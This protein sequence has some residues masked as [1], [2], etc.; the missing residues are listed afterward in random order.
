MEE[1]WQILIV[2]DD[3]LS[4]YVMQTAIEELYPAAHIISCSSAFK[5]LRYIKD[6]CMPTLEDPHVYCPQL[7][8]VDISMPLIDGYGFLTE[9]YNIEGLRYDYTSILLVSGHS[10]DEQKTKAQFFPILGYVEK[11]ITVEKLAYALK[12]I[13]PGNK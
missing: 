11:P 1:L 4:R 8:L 2:D 6:Y 12:K 5:A 7:I 3:Q 13:V 10:Y 9:L